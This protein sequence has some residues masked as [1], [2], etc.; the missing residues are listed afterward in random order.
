MKRIY[1]LIFVLF[2][3]ISASAQTPPSEAQIRKDVMNPGVLQIIFRG[4]GSFEK[5]V[6]G[7]AVVNEY[8][9][10]ITVRRKTDRPGVTVDVIG[11]VVY[12]LIGGRWVY[13]TMRLSGNQYSGLKNPTAA[14]INQALAAEEYQGFHG[15]GAVVEYESVKL[16]DAPVW[17]WHSMKSVSFYV[18]AVYRAV[19]QGRRY[20]NADPSTYKQGFETVE[21]VQE[22]W[23]MRIY[24][25]DEKSP[26]NGAS[27]TVVTEL[28]VPDG[29]GGK[30]PRNKLLER[31]L[32]PVEEVRQM[33]RVTRVPS[34]TQ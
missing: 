5:Y 22:V 33:A 2:C 19:S 14:E 27:L 28:E 3:S 7:G 15:N 25:Q 8:Y 32:Y 24:R 13:R 26:W 23:R 20:D 1:I 11:D 10:S 16:L 6:T 17:E 21:R 31:K 9:R 12:R 30:I 18:V 4:R 34:L 29:K